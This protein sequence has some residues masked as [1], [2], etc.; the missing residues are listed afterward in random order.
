[1]LFVDSHA[2]L[3]DRKYD[4]DREEMLQRAQ[5]RKICNIINVGYDLP[6]SRR[7]LALA[8]K[9]DFIYAAVGV[10]PHDAAEA[11]ENYLQ[12]LREMAAQPKA[13]AIGEMGLDY[14]RNL[15]P[16][17]IQQRVFREQI[18]LAAE[19]EKPIIIHDRE[20]H[21]DVMTILSEETLGQAKGVLHCF[22]GS[23]EMARECLKMGFYLSI[24]GPVTFHNANKLC[25]VA[26]NVPLDRLLI[27]TDAPYL[28]PEPHRGKR[29]ESA[30]VAYVGQR[31]AEIRGIPVE[32]L[33]AATTA[34]AKRLFK[35]G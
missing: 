18:R 32:E 1:M 9:Y 13:V 25:E 8:A 26:A 12:E 3:D 19:L 14:Y 23:L 35:I 16:K 27:E 24:A 5:D 7:S 11:G 29:N 4:G 22:S 20:A 34:N 2:H 31:I 21:G 10:H 33:A 17:E 15:S 28:T 30:Y 6:S